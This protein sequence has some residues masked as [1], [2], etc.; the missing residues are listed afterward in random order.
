MKGFFYVIWGLLLV[1]YGITII[2]VSLSI[3]LEGSIRDMI[4]VLNLLVSTPGLFI[5]GIIL[6]LQPGKTS[7]AVGLT[8]IVLAV[9]Y[10][11]LLI[12]SIVSSL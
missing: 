1:P 10:V 8:G 2:S 4:W 5:M 6:I 9:I 11:V 3:W 7:T 12:W